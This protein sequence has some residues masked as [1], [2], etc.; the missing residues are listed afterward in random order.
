MNVSNQALNTHVQKE[1]FR[2]DTKAWGDESATT[3]LL[4]RGGWFISTTLSNDAI[5]QLLRKVA[6]P[7]AEMIDSLMTLANVDITK[8]SPPIPTGWIPQPRDFFVHLETFV[9]ASP[10]AVLDHGTHAAGEPSTGRRQQLKAEVSRVVSNARDYLSL[11]SAEITGQ[12]AA[13]KTRLITDTNTDINEYLGNI[14]DLG[15]A[16]RTDDDISP[17]ADDDVQPVAPP[18]FSRLRGLTAEGS[19]NAIVGKLN[20]GLAGLPQ[21]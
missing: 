16:T 2:R 21:P 4:L 14:S 18:A 17:P 11:H 3:L 9:K 6:Y 12:E 10:F 20:N 13:V 8:F 19:A 1:R 15:V 7:D 5:A